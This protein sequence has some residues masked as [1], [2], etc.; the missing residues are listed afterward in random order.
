MQSFP[1]FSYVCYYDAGSSQK[2]TEAGNL[3]VSFK[4]RQLSVRIN[5]LI[6]C[7]WVNPL[8]YKVFF[9]KNLLKKFIFAG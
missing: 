4:V 6:E 3:F 7:G 5:R 2:V 9:E 1:G 8:I